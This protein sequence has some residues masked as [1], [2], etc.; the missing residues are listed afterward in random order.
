[1]KIAVYS[2]NYDNSSKKVMHDLLDLGKQHNV[3]FFIEKDFYSLLKINSS[4]LSNENIFS[5]Y[6]DLNNSF[7]ILEILI[8]LV[9]YFF[10]DSWDIRS[11]LC[12]IAAHFFLIR[13]F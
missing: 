12:V 6:N 8:Q 10:L 2:Q 1:M 7:V 5:S 13:I 11:R 9:I 4:N 3:E